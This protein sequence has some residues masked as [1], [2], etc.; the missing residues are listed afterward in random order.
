[1]DVIVMKQIKYVADIQGLKTYLY[2]TYGVFFMFLD[3][4]IR[5]FR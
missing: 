1:M 2:N 3:R 4:V 5:I